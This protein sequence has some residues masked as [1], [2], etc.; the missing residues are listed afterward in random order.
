MAIQDDLSKIALQEQSLVLPHFD[1]EVAWRIGTRLRDMAV[2]R[3]FGIVIDVRR[4]NQPL[5]YTALGG[6]SPSNSEWVRRKSNVVARFFRSSYAVGLDLIQKKT[7]LTD[8]QALPASDYAADG[9]SFPIRVA[10]AGV[11]GAVTVSG[12]AQRGD[13]ELVVEALCLE[14]GQNY[15]SLKLAPEE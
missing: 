7:N 1:H 6:T 14:T 12:L 10:N 8:R 5:F 3:N 13:H 4:F 2:A 9:G 11:I 15:E